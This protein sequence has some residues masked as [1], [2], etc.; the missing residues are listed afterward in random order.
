[1]RATAT[2]TRRRQLASIVL[3]GEAGHDWLV[4]MLGDDTIEGG[5]GNDVMFGGMA[6][7]CA[8][9]TSLGTSDF[10]ACRP[11]FAMA[12][13]RCIPLD[14]R[15][16]LLIPSH[17]GRQSSMGGTAGWP[18]H[19][20]GDDGNDVI[21]GGADVDELRGGA[22]MDYLDAGAGLD[23]VVE[24]ATDDDVMRGGEGDDELHGG[25][26]ID[27][28]YGDD[29]D[30]TLYGDAGNGDEPGWT[31]SLRWRRS[32]YA[33]RLL[34]PTNVVAIKTLLVGD[35]L[36][37]GAGGDFLHGNSARKFWSA[38]GKRLHRRRRIRLVPTTHAGIG[39]DAD[40]DWCRRHCSWAVAAKI[41]S[42]AVAVTTRSGAVRAPTTSS[43][44][45]AVTRSTV[46]A[47]STCS[48]CRLRLVRM[49]T[50]TP[51][52]TPSMATTAIVEQG[53][54][55]DDNATDILAIDGTT[56]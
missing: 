27:Q 7:R 56:A 11:E 8:V 36:F 9:I 30:D 5:A 32:R 20:D 44:K 22:G 15:Q 18:R 52:P 41:N 47:A 51:A 53:D 2:M 1:M 24:A 46:A 17:R 21:F 55:P 50:S 19:L 42:T 49:A 35:Q 31:T 45:T 40:A 12:T 38:A 37:G 14:T 48:S 4:G 39:P 28:V 23:L 29:G 25:T 54:V 43:A 33:V 3:K 13:K 16:R 6:F 10:D 26:G 34:A